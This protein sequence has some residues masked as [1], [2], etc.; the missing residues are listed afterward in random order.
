MV[1]KLLI[2]MTKVLVA[3][4]LAGLLACTASHEDSA[5]ADVGNTDT[6]TALIIFAAKD[7][8][9]DGVNDSSDNCILTRNPLQRDTDAD[10]YGNYCDTDFNNDHIVNAADLGYLKIKFLWQ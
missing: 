3:V 8:D 4:P 6:P 2:N 5:P 10:G 1:Y 7:T 9:G